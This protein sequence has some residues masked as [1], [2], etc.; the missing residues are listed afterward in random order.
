MWGSMLTT[1]ALVMWTWVL[2][3]GAP[4][5]CRYKCKQQQHQNQM[6]RYCDLLKVPYWNCCILSFTSYIFTK[7]L[8]LCFCEF[9]DIMEQ[10]VYIW[11]C[12]LGVYYARPRECQNNLQTGH[13][14]KEEKL[15]PLLSHHKGQ[16]TLPLH[17]FLNQ[18]IH[19]LYH[20]PNQQSRPCSRDRTCLNNPSKGLV[21]VNENFKLWT[22]Y[23]FWVSK[24]G[25]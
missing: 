2:K 22:V 7:Y 10:W 20:I 25:I 5:M 18:H 14:G 15:Q 12:A 24:Q 16:A 9:F 3:T 17:Q 6:R 11:Y 1:K 19:F 4:T 21:K 8:K 13:Q 23:C